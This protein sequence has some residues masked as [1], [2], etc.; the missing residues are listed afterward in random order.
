MRA[1]PLHKRPADFV[2]TLL[3]S[4]TEDTS[5]D[6][7]ALMT[8]LDVLLPRERSSTAGRDRVTR[9][10]MAEVRRLVA[11]GYLSRTEYRPSWSEIAF[12]RYV[13]TDKRHPFTGY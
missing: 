7:G 2:K 6:F 1:T 3:L 5:M 12:A 11:E 13:R 10:A 9:E 8:L 4:L